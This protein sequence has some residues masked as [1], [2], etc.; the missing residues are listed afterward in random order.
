MSDVF[1][2]P[3]TVALQAPVS[4]GFSRQEDRS[5]LPCPAPGDLPDPGVEPE[6]PMAPA[7]QVDSLSL[8]HRGSLVFTASPGR[9]HTGCA[10]YKEASHPGYPSANFQ[11][12]SWRSFCPRGPPVGTSHAWRL[13][14]AASLHTHTYLLLLQSRLPGSVRLLIFCSFSVLVFCFF[15][16]S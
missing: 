3:W 6:F 9:M 4:M 16:V 2:T 8:S 15:T 7:L 11:C 10:S 14:G 13:F 1:V 5:G 12:S